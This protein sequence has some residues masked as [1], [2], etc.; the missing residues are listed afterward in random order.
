MARAEVV[1]KLKFEKSFFLY[2]EEAELSARILKQNLKIARL[3][4]ARSYHLESHSSP[5]TF[6]DGVAFRQFYG[7][8]NR[9]FMLGKHWPCRLMFTALLVNELH[10]LYLIYFFI[11]NTKINYT[12]L[13]YIAPIGFIR[14]WR[15]RDR[16]KLIDANWYT[17]LVPVSLRNYFKLGKKVF[18][19]S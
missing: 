5:K 1:K 15:A 13:L 17:K 7:V 8:Q 3:A 16:K 4:K 14:G 6:T 10:L 19:K 11:I 9:W 18:S 12:K 2:Y